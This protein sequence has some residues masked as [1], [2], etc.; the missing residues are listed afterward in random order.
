MEIVVLP[1]RRFVLLAWLLVLPREEGGT[2]EIVDRFET[3]FSYISILVLAVHGD[4]SDMSTFVPNC[5]RFSSP[6]NLGSIAQHGQT[7]L[8]NYILRSIM[9]DKLP[10][11]YLET[12]FFSRSRNFV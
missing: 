10:S 9:M 5:D 2:R 11:R 7:V 4:M 1:C 12:C 6:R 8:D 3:S